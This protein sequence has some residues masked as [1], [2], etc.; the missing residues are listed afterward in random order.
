M[1]AGTNEGRKYIGTTY[2]K[3]GDWRGRGWVPV[4]NQVL[5]DDLV[6]SIS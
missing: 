3:V 1:S 5:I 4:T 2:D 6:V